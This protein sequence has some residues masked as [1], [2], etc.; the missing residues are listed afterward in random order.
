VSL[1]H[2]GNL[3]QRGNHPTSSMHR[4]GEGHWGK[5]MPRG[6]RNREGTAISKIFGNNHPVT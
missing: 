4:V 5:K 1:K 6:A 3:T 2:P